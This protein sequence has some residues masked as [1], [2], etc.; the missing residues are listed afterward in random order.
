[1][2]TFTVT[3]VPDLA[4]PVVDLASA[5]YVGETVLV[6]DTWRTARLQVR[7]TDDRSGISGGTIYVATPGGPTAYLQSPR[8][9]SG[10]ATDGVWEFTGTIPAYAPVGQWRVTQIFVQ[11]RVNRHVSIGSPAGLP[12]F[13]VRCPTV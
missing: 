8:L 1:L 7:L 10:T 6:N 3:G 13:T 11:D 2:P 4:A 9:V 12:T 5:R